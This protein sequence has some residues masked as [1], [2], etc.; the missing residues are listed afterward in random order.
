M[1]H[2]YSKVAQQLRVLVRVTYHKPELA[3]KQ[4]VPALALVA[5]PTFGPD[6]AHYCYGGST[7]PYVPPS[8]QIWPAIL[9]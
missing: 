5:S 7:D 1:A 2:I 6:L 3:H 8:N 9:Y 4:S